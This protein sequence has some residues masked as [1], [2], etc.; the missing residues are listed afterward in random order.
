MVA[1]AHEHKVFVVASNHEFF[2]TPKPDELVRRLKCMDEMGADLPK[3]AVMPKTERDVL[4]LLS[5]TLAYYEAG[6]EKPVI[7]MSMNQLGV[8]SRLAGELYGSSM[9]FATVGKT[10]APG[11]LS[12][13][14]VRAVLQMLHK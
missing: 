13:D 8:V 4:N 3:L 1:L 11:Q 6:G 12:I 7:T 2:T 5:A 14:K 9:T 10:S